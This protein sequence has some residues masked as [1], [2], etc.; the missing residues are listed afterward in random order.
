MFSC[1]LL[2][3]DTQV[4]ADQLCV[5]TDYCLEDLRW[6]TADRYK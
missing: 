6:G 1:G 2:H 3:M 4:L 5:D